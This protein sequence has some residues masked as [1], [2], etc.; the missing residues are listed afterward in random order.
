MKLELGDLLEQA[1]GNEASGDRRVNPP[2]S[3]AMH[4]RRDSALQR[5]RHD[6]Q[7][8]RSM[9]LLAEYGSDSDDE[10]AVLPPPPVASTA[11]QQEQEPVKVR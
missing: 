1:V 3:Y 5:D 9:D 7:D 4:S 11:P 8:R 2:A 10:V 6:R